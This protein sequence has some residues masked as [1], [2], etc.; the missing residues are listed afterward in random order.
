LMGQDGTIKLLAVPVQ[1]RH[2]GRLLTL[3]TSVRRLVA[4]NGTVTCVAVQPDMSAIRAFTHGSRALREVAAPALP[5]PLSLCSGLR[6][7]SYCYGDKRTGRVTS[8][9]GGPSGRKGRDNLG[10]LPTA[11]TGKLRS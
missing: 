10:Q 2:P 7:V 4:H 6:R 11:M 3:N 1:R 8:P 5:W 9:K